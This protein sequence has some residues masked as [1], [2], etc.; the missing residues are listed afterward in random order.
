MCSHGRSTLILGF[1]LVLSLSGCSKK[2]SPTQPAPNESAASLVLRAN[3]R[4]GQIISHQLDPSTDHT[5]PSEIDLR[6]PYNLYQQA[7]AKDAANLDAHFGVAVLEVLTLTTDS[8]VNA[9]FD[10]WKAYLAAHTPFE[11]P[12]PSPGPMGVP[13]RLGGGRDVLRLPFEGIP[14]AALA[15]SRGPFLAADPQISRVQAILESRARLAACLPRPATSRSPTSWALRPTT[16]P[17]WST[18][19][20]RVAHG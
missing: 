3:L 11:L 1:I 10:E 4:L 8:E 18:A 12:L 19:S 20:P 15:I 16:V 13:A 17:R 7:L 9:A 6:E 5:R 14:M 2:S